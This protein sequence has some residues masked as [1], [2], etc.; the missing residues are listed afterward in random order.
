MDSANGWMNDY[1]VV[2]LVRLSVV[3]RQQGMLVRYDC[4]VGTNPH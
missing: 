3:Y 4:Y 2:A 1:I